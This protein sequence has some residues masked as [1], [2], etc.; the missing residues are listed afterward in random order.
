MGQ[1]PDITIFDMGYNDNPNMTMWICRT[2][3]KIVPDITILVVHSLQSAEISTT[4]IL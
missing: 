2:E 1:N 3:R 4:K